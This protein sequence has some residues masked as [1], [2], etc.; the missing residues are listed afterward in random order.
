MMKCEHVLK[1]E[2][3]DDIA[4]EDKEGL[5]VLPED[6]TSQ[7][8][9]AGSAEWLSLNGK[10]D[11]DTKLFFVLLHPSL[12][13]LRSVVDS[14]HNILDTGLGEAFNLMKNHRLVGKGNERLGER[15]GKRP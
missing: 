12:H 4:V 7:S 2:I 6:F 15:Q 10:S 5:I 8:Q 14:K 3:T 13:D 1:G 11:L 9:G